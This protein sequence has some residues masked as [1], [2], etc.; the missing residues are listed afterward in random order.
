M[1][2]SQR[3][4]LLVVDDHFVVRMGLASMINSEDDMC[5]VAN[6]G[7]GADALAAYREHRP[8]VV[9]LDLRLPD[10]SGVEVTAEI[11]AEAPDARVII[12]TTFAGD[13]NIYRAFQAGVQAYLQ[14]DVPKNLLLHTVRAVH[15]GDYAIPSQIAGVLARRIMAPELTKREIE[16][17]S[18]IVKGMSNKEIGASLCVTESTVK[19]HVNVILSKLQ[20][21]DRTQAATTAIRRGII[22]LDES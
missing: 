21:N 6:A 10:R 15:R 19:Q 20:V 12:L 2:D 17:L 1:N 18:L 14:K 22:P 3:I 9:L 16:V 4:R 13:E 7:T 5:V 11:R 8:D